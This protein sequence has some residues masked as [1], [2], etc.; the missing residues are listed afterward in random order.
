M[1]AASVAQQLINIGVRAVVAAGWAVDD[2]AGKDFGIQFY[3][4]ML[5]EQGQFGE[6]VLHRAPLH[7]R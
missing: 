2:Q 1:L 7:P 4:Q 5:A 3:R 6:A